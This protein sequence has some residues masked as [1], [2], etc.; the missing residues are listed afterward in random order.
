MD[1]HYE[2]V[3]TVISPGLTLIHWTSINLD[4][5]ITSVTSSLKQL[6][7][8]VDRLIDTNENRIGHI[9]TEI[10]NITLVEL[11]E[12]CTLS[13]SEFYQTTEKLCAA[14]TKVLENKSKLLERIVTEVLDMLMGSKVILENTEDKGKAG[15][16]SLRR[17]VESRSRLLLEAENV[18]ISYEQMLMESLFHL[19]RSALEAI[20]RRLSVRMLTYGERVK[21]KPNEPLFEAELILAI[22]TILMKP[23]LDDIQQ[24]LNKVV[25]TITNITMGV[26]RWGQPKYSVPCPPEDERPLHTRSALRKH[27]LYSL[28]PSIDHIS[29]KT[30]HHTVSKHKEIQKLVSVLST[31]INPTKL[32]VASSTKKYTRYAHLW[33][34]EK[35]TRMKEYMEN[36]NPGV[37]EF[38]RE[39]SDYA[40]LA[41][42]IAMESDLLVAGAVSLSTEKLKLALTTEARVWIVF[43]GRNMNHKYQL[44]MEDVFRSIDNWSN[45][46]N[47]K[48]EDL[49]DVRYL[50]AALK[51]VRENEIRIEMSLDPIE[52]CEHNRC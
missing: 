17:R 27:T 8:L 6:E 16:L 47:R 40:S 10:T 19:L 33:K 37:S 14:A 52:V 34:L 44:V 29:L 1:I 38:R 39:M 36:L 22:P 30:F 23:S 5:Y 3:N 20:R 11:P 51:E 49:D 7:I 4:A 18:Q 25:C 15:E 24:W 35:K 46:L 43:F 13:A 12:S 50:M 32:V 48:L 2:K 21:E 9:L 26:Y 42:V 41:E 31:A 45:R 28:P